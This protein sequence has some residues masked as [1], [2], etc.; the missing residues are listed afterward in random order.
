MDKIL[1]MIKKCDAALIDVQKFPVIL[2]VHENEQKED[3]E[4]EE[5][6]VSAVHIDPS[7]GAP[8]EYGFTSEAL[9]YAI[10]QSDGTILLNAMDGEPCELRLL[11]KIEREG[12]TNA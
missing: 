12:T 9:H 7:D 10:I 6:V 8:Y 1:S 11:K 5:A 4:Y 3:G 2:K